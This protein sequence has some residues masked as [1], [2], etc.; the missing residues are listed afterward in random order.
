MKYKVELAKFYSIVVEADSR[1]E[2]E[3]KA[4]VMAVERWNRRTEL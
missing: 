2:A 1:K 4:A 3:N